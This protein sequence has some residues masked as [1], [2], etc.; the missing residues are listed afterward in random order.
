MSM[1]RRPSQSAVRPSARRVRRGFSFTEILFAVMILGIG[2]IMVAAMFPVAI[3]QTQATSDE[4]I[5]ASVG[6]TG[7]DFMTQLAAQRVIPDAND[8][9][10]I[11][12]VLPKNLSTSILVPTYRSTQ[13]SAI[14]SAVAAPPS[15]YDYAPV[16]FAG[17]VWSLREDPI[18]NDRSNVYLFD[19][20]T[21][22]SSSAL[23][24]HS[25]AMWRAI[26]NNLIIPT[27]SQF[28]W[29]G[30]Y[31]RDIIVQYD[32]TVG[33]NVATP[34]PTAQ[35]FVLAVQERNKPI[36]EPAL[37]ISHH[38]TANSPFPATLEPQLV[39]GVSITHQ[40]DGTSQVVV[41]Q[42][43]AS[44]I[45]PGTYVVV[46]HD[47]LTGAMTG[48]MNGR[49]FQIGIQPNPNNPTLWQLAPGGDLG[50][51]DPNIVNGAIF[52]VGRG[53][54]NPQSPTPSPAAFKGPAQDVAIF[55]SFIPVN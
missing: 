47:N 35:I 13:L 19:Q 2:F 33:H 48:A 10:V 1:N 40:P 29:V 23:F 41:N 26:A 53:Y 30:M 45:A 3:Q 22:T 31:K 39:Y 21:S 36:Y 24:P 38:P 46:A 5:A 37:D 27:D 28:G 50:P 6:R 55:T 15:G 4:T 16:V 25:A 42:P 9:L 44:K 20:G 32:A 11:N 51:S 7:A 49:V 8:P 52:I 54:A 12:G 34:A 18:A 17:D 43:Y 14:A